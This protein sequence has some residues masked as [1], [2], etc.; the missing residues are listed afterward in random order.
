MREDF[1]ILGTCVH[2]R[3]LVYLDNAAT[4]QPPRQVL[5]AVNELY[6]THNGNVHRSGHA[7]GRTTSEK[8]E[9]A[10]ESVRRFLNARDCAE[11]VFTSGTTG[12]ID[13]LARIC[14]EQV[15]RPGDEVITTELEHHSNLL[16]WAAACERSGAVLRLVPMDEHGDLDQDAYRAMLSEKTKLV[17]VTWV[18]NAIGT[19]NPVRE[20]ITQAHAVGAAVLVDAAQAM[21]HKSVDVQALDCD[22]LAF[23]GHKVGAL[24]G[25]GVLYGKKERLEGFTPV[26]LGGGMVRSVRGVQAEYVSLP[27]RFE[28]GTPNYAGAISLGA[29]LTWL[30]EH[31]REDLARHTQELLEETEQILSRADVRILGAP[32]ERAGVISFTADGV[33]PYDLAQLLDQQGVAVRSGHHCAQ[34]AVSHFGVESCVRV[35]P[36]FYNTRDDLARFEKALSRSLLLL[37]K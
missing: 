18:S 4:L 31:G 29:A 13:L 17:A 22:Y 36:A 10:R 32:K 20:M 30:E 16:P 11:I 24:T 3:P 23:S 33:H 28:A 27:H 15:L 1:T 14:A 12:S 6:S 5:N 34:N 8:M 7:L 37:R 25:T 9:G 26:C 21:L 2:G 19:V 35:S